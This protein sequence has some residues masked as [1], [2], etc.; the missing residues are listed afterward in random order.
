VILESPTICPR[1][2]GSFITS[3]QRN[4]GEE[5]IIA[6]PEFI[7]FSFAKKDFYKYNDPLSNKLKKYRGVPVARV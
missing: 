5:V 4:K 1:A 7:N 2:D 6:T 3:R